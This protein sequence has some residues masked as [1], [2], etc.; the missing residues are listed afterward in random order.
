MSLTAI[1]VTVLVACM[2]LGPVL[3][4]RPSPRQKRIAALRAKASG[5]GLAVRLHNFEDTP[6]ANYLVRWPSALKWPHDCEVQLML[7]SYQHELHVNGYWEVHPSSLDPHLKKVLQK[8]LPQVQEDVQ[9]V[10][11]LEINSAG[12]SASWGEQG[13]LD[14]LAQLNQHLHSLATQLTP[15]GET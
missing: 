7:K 12:V 4:L 11:S 9:G 5:L 14:A 2:A 8:W 3:L 13:G 15:F 1:V 6:I 10:K